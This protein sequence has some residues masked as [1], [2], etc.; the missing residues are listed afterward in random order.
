MEEWAA[1][2]PAPA[3]RAVIEEGADRLDDDEGERIAG[4]AAAAYPELWDSLVEDIGDAHEAR[5]LVVLGSVVALLAEER[6]LDAWRL[7]HLEEC[8]DCWADPSSA[9][10]DVV[11]PCDLWSIADAAALADALDQAGDVE[12]DRFDAVVAATAGAL[13]TTA[14]GRRLALLVGRVRQRLPQ[15]MRP[16]ASRALAAACARFDR[17]EA[18]RARTAALMLADTLAPLRGV[19]AVGARVAA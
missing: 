6:D 18:V 14:H 9:L 3:T 5:S 15:V 11:Q 16:R 7:D 19:E 1:S 13:W 4:W 12:G 17:D 10:A 8:D 2:A